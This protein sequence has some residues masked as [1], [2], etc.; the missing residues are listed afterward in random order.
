MHIKNLTI[1]YIVVLEKFYKKPF[2]KNKL[3]T[4]NNLLSPRLLNKSPPP[5]LPSNKDVLIEKHH[6][7]LRNSPY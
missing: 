2:K 3:N 1:K 4:I 6:L 7:S 5:H